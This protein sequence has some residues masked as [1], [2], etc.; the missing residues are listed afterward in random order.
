MATRLGKVSIKK[1]RRYKGSF[2]RQRRSCIHTVS[3]HECRQR[4]KRDREDLARE[5][6][7]EGELDWISDE[8]G[9]DVTGNGLYWFWDSVW[10]EPQF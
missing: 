9:V 7:E 2:Y 5:H 10:N 6:L 8:N 4:K 3:R 1:F